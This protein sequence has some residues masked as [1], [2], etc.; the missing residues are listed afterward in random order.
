MKRALPTL[1]VILIAISLCSCGDSSGPS[2][3]IPSTQTNVAGNNSQNSPE[4]AA[5]EPD[6]V[7]NEVEE[8]AYEVTYT[9]AK[10][11]TNSIGTVWSQV[12]VEIENTGSSD[13]YLSSGSYDLE[14]ADGNLIAS[15]T[16]VSAY[17]EVISP[18]EKAYMY[19]ETTLDNAVEGDIVVLARPSVDKAKVDNIRYPVTDISISDG[20]YG[21]LKTLGRVE[22]TSDED[23][24]MTYIV[25]IM[26][27]SSGIPIGQMFTILTDDLKAGDKIGFEMSAFA[28]PDDITADSV[29]DFIAYAYPMQMQF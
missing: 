28:L 4:D 2:S 27:D 20:K 7:Q 21:D 19:N 22:N 1:L 29:A 13:L 8:V 25:V 24:S 26:K 23:S 6:P 10:I 11:Y 9:N 16:M 15:E 14:D 17:P 12:I 3:D 18:G 5:Q